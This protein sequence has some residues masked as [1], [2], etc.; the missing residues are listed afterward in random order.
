[1]QRIKREILP[2]RT[3]SPT[4]PAPNLVSP[5]EVPVSHGCGD[6]FESLLLI[7]VLRSVANAATYL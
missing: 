5:I 4:R 3:S 1:M 7:F 2:S 6:P